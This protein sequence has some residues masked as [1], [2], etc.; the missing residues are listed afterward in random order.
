MY[1]VQQLLAHTPPEHVE[2]NALKS[3]VKVLEK[4]NQ[5]I[6]EK[7]SMADNI[8]QMLE[9]ERKIVGGCPPLLDEE[10]VKMREGMKKSMYSIEVDKSPPQVW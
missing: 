2:Y 5:M 6:N 8:R 9:F 1:S 3:V 7:T 10:Q 4:M